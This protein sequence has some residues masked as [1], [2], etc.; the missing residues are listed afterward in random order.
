MTDEIQ[1]KLG[2]Y[3]L[4]HI[5]DIDCLRKGFKTGRTR[6]VEWRK[7]QLRQLKKGILEM[8][9]E[10]TGALEQDLGKSKFVSEF[11]SLLPC[12]WDIDYSLENV[13]KV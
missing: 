5:F 3:H 12:I 13:E 2:I 6:D 11:T 1:I 4:N 7:E 9:D 10:L 8:K